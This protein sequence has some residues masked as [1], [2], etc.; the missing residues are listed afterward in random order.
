MEQF[1][2]RNRGQG[3]LD[4]S[5][6]SARISE[7]YGRLVKSR[8]V[9]P[10]WP[11]A[12]RDKTWIGAN[13]G[14]HSSEDMLVEIQDE[15]VAFVDV[16]EGLEDAPKASEVFDNGQ[17]GKIAFKLDDAWFTSKLIASGWRLNFQDGSQ[18][19]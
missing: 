11:W 7:F 6:K 9:T 1:R 12:A 8:A 15:L 4:M 5:Q 18:A 17:V 13:S 3:I 19:N 10:A 14:L 16:W 2:E